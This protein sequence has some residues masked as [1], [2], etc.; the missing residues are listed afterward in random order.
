MAQACVDVPEIVQPLRLPNC[1][2][3]AI[4]E[5]GSGDTHI[6]TYFS[7]NHGQ[8]PPTCPCEAVDEDNGWVVRHG[9]QAA[10]EVLQ[11]APAE[12]E[13]EG[14]PR[15]WLTSKGWGLSALVN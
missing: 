9:Q 5:D 15:P 2:R 11:G 12:G 4:D 10:D 1:P 14:A 3:C 13:R 6:G 8:A 7:V